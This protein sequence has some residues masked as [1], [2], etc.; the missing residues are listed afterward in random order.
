MLFVLIFW[1]IRL[2]L[3][4]I[5]RF[6]NRS[7]WEEL[8]Y[9]D[10]EEFTL[11]WLRE[12][13]LILTE[14][15][16]P[17]SDWEKLTLFWQREIYLILTERNLPGSDWEELN[18]IFLCFLRGTCFLANNLNVSFLWLWI[19]NKC[20]LRYQLCGRSLAFSLEI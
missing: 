5:C 19:I 8:P 12:I 20:Y 4:C 15:N 9:S 10:W 17:Y 14:R 7:D 6:A 3:H 2:K 11:F 1:I 16:L 18:L 13:Y